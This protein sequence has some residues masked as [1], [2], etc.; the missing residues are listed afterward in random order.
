VI[1]FWSLA[2]PEAL[3]ASSFKKILTTKGM[4]E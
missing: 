2:K 3:R 1:G 4:K